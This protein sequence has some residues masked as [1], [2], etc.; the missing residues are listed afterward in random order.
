MDPPNSRSWGRLDD[1]EFEAA[2]DRLQDYGLDPDGDYYESYRHDAPSSHKKSKKSRRKRSRTRK[3]S[4]LEVAPS[5]VEP[6]SEWPARDEFFAGRAAE[7][8]P[9]VWSRNTPVAGGSWITQQRR[10]LYMLV[11][12]LGVV[13]IVG[14]ATGISLSKKGGQATSDATTDSGKDIEAA[15]IAVHDELAPSGA[16][17]AA[18]GARVAVTQ[19]AGSFTVRSTSS[20]ANASPTVAPGQEGDPYPGVVQTTEE[21]APSQ[22]TAD[23]ATSIVVVSANVTTTVAYKT[24]TT[25]KPATTSR[26]GEFLQQI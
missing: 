25:S 2:E 8:V 18:Q 11:A 19:T 21:G 3:S 22:P 9:D 1:S 13:L 26:A 12:I 24:T 16:A 7:E 23:V 15:R 6:Q 10:R 4:K 5:V 14:L 17:V 20:S